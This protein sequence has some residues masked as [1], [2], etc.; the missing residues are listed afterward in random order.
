MAYAT[1]TELT[2]FLDPE[3]VPAG[4]ARLLDRASR[5]VDLALECAIYAVDAGGLPTDAGIAATLKEATLEQAAWRI[6]NGEEHGIAS[7]A[8]SAAIGSVNVTRA[9]SGAAGSGSVGDLGA[10]A[11][12]VLRLAGLAADGPVIW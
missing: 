4:A 9:A 5:D 6:E 1:V 10:Q 11:Y 8:G 3:P 7:P 2:G 12:N